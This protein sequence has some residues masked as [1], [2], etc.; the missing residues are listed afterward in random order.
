MVLMNGFVE[1]IKWLLVI[2][3]NK[4]FSRCGVKVSISLIYDRRIILIEIR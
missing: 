1:Y 4:D 2:I 3:A